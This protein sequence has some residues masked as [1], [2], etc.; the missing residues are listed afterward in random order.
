[1]SP[2][3][4][5]KSGAFRGVVLLA[6]L[7]APESFAQSVAPPVQPPFVAL[8]AAALAERGAVIGSVNLRIDD[9][10][11]PN[12][13]RE[14]KRLYRWANKIHV[15]T[16]PS[17]VESILLFEPGDPLDPRLLEESA[18]LLRERDFSAE[19][20]IGA[21]S[22]DATTNAVGVDVW[23]RDAWSLEPDLKFSRSG[24]EN[25][26]GIGLSEDNL[27]GFGKS[28][29]LAYSSDVDRNSTVL[30]YSDRNVNDSRTRL[31]F[32]VATMS[33]G[34]NI[35]FF[36]ERPFYSL[37]TRWTAAGGYVDDERIDSMYDLGEIVDEFRH[38]TNYLTVQG[39]WSRGIVGRSARR[40]YTGLTMDEDRFSPTIDTPQPLFLP[41]NRKLVY[42]WIGWQ[43]VTDDFRQV[44]ELNDIGRTEDVALG[45][46]L[47]LSIGRATDNLGADR[48]ATIVEGRVRKGWEPGGPGGLLLIEATAGARDESDGIHNA[49]FSTSARYYHRTFGSE[50]FLTSLTTVHGNNLD[51]ENQVLLGG[52]NGLRGYPLRYQSGERSAVFTIEQRFFTDWYPFRLLRFGYAVFMDAGRVSGADPRGSPSLGTLYDV[53][54]GLRLTSPRSSGGSVL[55]IDLAFPVNAPPD[56]DDVQL[57]IEK[58][59]SF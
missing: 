8:D 6:A 38:D 45:L 14:D 56:I 29:S 16:R 5:G 58:K 17:V 37:D 9:V 12:D 55:H 22:Y 23:L 53:G 19:A 27:F 33:D 41:G 30:A 26:W 18:R 36:A 59:A 7:A 43:F 52:D 28:L 2:A 3:D 10:F 47:Y 4:L 49:V 57:I 51:L 35:R 39:G 13:P 31:D 40:W 54:V 32:S 42:P 24:G 20:A 50:L 11:D 1:M 25:E 44:T 15:T 34:G 48:D 21:T 46:D